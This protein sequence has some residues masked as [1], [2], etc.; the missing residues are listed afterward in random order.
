VKPAKNSL[1]QRHGGTEKMGK[2]AVTVCV[3]LKYEKGKAFLFFDGDVSVWIPKSQVSRMEKL[4]NN[5]EY[6]EVDIPE[7]MALREGLI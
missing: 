4:G 1:T 5:G 7:W 6:Y 2:Q 3:E